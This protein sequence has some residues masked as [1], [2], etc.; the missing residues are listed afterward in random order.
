MTLHAIKIIT[1][2][3]NYEHIMEFRQS[4]DTWNRVNDENNNREAF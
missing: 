1:N 3:L 4:L 2:A